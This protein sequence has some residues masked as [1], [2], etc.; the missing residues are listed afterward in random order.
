MPLQPLLE[1]GLV[2]KHSQARRERSDG[3]LD[4]VGKRLGRGPDRAKSPE[5]SGALPPCYVAGYAETLLFSPT[6]AF[7][8]IVIAHFG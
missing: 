8:S 1:G 7:R 4:M 5:N 3:L 2:G 6:C